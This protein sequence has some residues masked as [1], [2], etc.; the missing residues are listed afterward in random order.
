MS[1]YAETE[2]WTVKL[3]TENRHN[4]RH[5]QSAANILTPCESN[6]INQ[7]LSP[8][9]GNKICTMVISAW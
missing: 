8:I 7:N 9:H 1:Y 2:L 3:P 5:S 6:S 4:P